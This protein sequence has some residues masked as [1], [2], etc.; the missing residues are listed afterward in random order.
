MDRM[1]IGVEIHSVRG[2]GAQRSGDD[3]ARKPLHVGARPC[4]PT[5]AGTTPGHPMVYLISNSPPQ[6]PNLVCIFQ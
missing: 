1:K 6:G 4:W 2:G 5:A 3:F